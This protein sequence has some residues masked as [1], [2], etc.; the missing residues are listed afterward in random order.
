MLAV[1]EATGRPAFPGSGEAG[2]ALVPLSDSVDP[3]ALDHLF[4]GDASG[5]VVFDYAGCEVVVLDGIR[6]VVTPQE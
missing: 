5:R 4:R 3:D 6:V 2:G 1:S